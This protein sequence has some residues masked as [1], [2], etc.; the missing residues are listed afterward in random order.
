MFRSLKEG[1]FQKNIFCNPYEDVNDF[2]FNWFENSFL[3]FFEEWKQSIERRPGN[4][5]RNAK[6]CMFISHQTYEGL[7]II[8]SSTIELQNICYI[9]AVFMY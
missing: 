3:K 5:T 1:K 6:H 7:Q 8:V 9:M 2:R 4:F